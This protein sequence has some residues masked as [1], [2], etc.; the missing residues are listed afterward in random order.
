MG[1][2]AAHSLGQLDHTGAGFALKPLKRSIKKDVHA[3]GFEV[4]AE[5]FVSVYPFFN[6]VAQVQYVIPRGIGKN[7][8][9]RLAKIKY[10]LYD[11]SPLTKMLAIGLSEITVNTVYNL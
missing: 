5:K 8:L 11:L 3:F 2:A 9:P 1:F 10:R 4:L 7:A 6:Q